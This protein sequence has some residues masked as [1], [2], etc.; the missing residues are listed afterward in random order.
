MLLSPQSSVL[1]PRPRHG[2]TLVGVI[3]YLLG[4]AALLLLELH[5]FLR[6]ALMIGSHAD[7]LSRQKLHALAWL[8]FSII[9]VYLVSGLILVFRVGRFFFPREELTGRR[10]RTPHIDIWAE[11]GKRIKLDEDEPTDDRTED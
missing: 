11:A 10:V 7:P 1:S 4:F 9:L 5:Y 6:P 3:A 2:R 8:M